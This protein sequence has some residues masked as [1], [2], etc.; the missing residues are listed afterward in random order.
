[1]NGE[2]QKQYPI[3]FRCSYVP[4]RKTILIWVSNAAMFEIPFYILK[5]FYYKMDEAQK[6]A[7]SQL[8]VPDNRIVVPGK[9]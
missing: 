7:Q 5:E 8:L 2:P 6:A 9:Q 1:M 4:E 3:E